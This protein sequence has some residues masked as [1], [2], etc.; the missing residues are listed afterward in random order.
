MKLVT[1][2]IRVDFG[3]D[4][5][6]NFCYRKP[7]ILEKIGTERPDIICFQEVADHVALWLKENLKDYN[8]IGC[9][10]GTDLRGEQLSIAYRK[11][12][13]NLME[14]HT[15]WLSDTPFVPGSRYREQSV[16]PRVCTE[17]L[18]EELST[19]LV[20][21]LVNIH[22]DYEGASARRQGLLRI[23]EE[24]GKRELFPQAPVILAGDLNAKGGSDEL[25]VLLEHPDLRNLTAGIGA[26]FHDFGRGAEDIDYIFAHRDFVCD[27]VE[28]WTDRSEEGVYLSDH[29]PVCATLHCAMSAGNQARTQ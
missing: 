18:L 28:K 1:F 20:F 14:M 11:D 25:S 17:V 24:L 15:F 12:A 26:T 23:L 5:A 13:M 29:Y 22:L 9:G 27:K 6:Q 16:C 19:G 7:L 4:G 3:G 10:R 2:N 21:R 8:V